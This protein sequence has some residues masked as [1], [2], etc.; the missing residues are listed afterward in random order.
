MAQPANCGQD[1]AAA[2]GDSCFGLRRFRRRSNTRVPVELVIHGLGQASESGEPL[3][4]L[5]EA[6]R[7][8]YLVI[9]IGPLELMG[10]A[11]AVSNTKPPRPMTHD[12]LCSAIEAC[13]GRVTHAVIH[14]IIDGAFHARL[15]LDVQGRHV[16]LD[17]RSSDAI[18]VAVR[19]GIP[20]QAEQSVLDQA[21]VTPK[22][23]GAA[24]ETPSEQERIRED[25]LGAFRDVISGL[26]LDDL[27]GPRRSS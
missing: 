14:A 17:S 15:V 16:E 1:A 25:Q 4:L 2:A 18:A 26:D 10:I 27:G 21:G 8:R 6:A 22:A 24:E 9:G 12:L 5:K 3:V 13:G 19:A 23:E 20:I 11:A 7:E